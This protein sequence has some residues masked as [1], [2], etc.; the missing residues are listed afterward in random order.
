MIYSSGTHCLNKRGQLHLGRYLAPC[1]RILI[2]SPM[3][4]K[5]PGTYG[6][7]YLIVKIFCFYNSLSSYKDRK[8]FILFF[9]WAQCWI[10]GKLKSKIQFQ[11]IRIPH[12]IP[13]LTD[14]CVGKRDVHRI[15]RSNGTN[16]SYQGNPP[17]LFLT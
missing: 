7:F 4:Q 3:P 12:S 10:L 14:N 8:S 5:N 6:D 9:N 13:P 15:M 1:S 16:N 2:Y 11:V 17:F